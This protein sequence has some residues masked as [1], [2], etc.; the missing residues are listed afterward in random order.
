MMIIKSL[1][2][3]EM[4]KTI[5]QIMGVRSQLVND[6]QTEFSDSPMGDRKSVV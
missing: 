4:K 5:D 2:I 1:Q 6:L 3:E